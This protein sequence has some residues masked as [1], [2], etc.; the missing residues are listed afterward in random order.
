MKLTAQHRAPDRERERGPRTTEDNYW[1]GI[2]LHFQLLKPISTLSIVTMLLSQQ[3]GCTSAPSDSIAERMVPDLKIHT[4][5]VC[6]L[7]A[8][9]SDTSNKKKK[10]RADD[11]AA[12]SPGIHWGL[13]GTFAF[14]SPSP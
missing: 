10:G 12:V 8:E 1:G 2:W 11:D 6:V 14:C 5:V 7:R 3:L 4:S 9:N 13:F